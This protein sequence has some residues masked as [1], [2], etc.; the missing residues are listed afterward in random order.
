MEKQLLLIN[1]S[2]IESISHIEENEAGKETNPMCLLIIP[3]VSNSI[4]S[5]KER[6][7]SLNFNYNSI[8]SDLNQTHCYIKVR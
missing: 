2:P 8:W 7:E 3:K 1:D 6:L 4:V 5:L